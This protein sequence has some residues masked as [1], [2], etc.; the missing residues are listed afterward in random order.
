MKRLYYALRLGD[1]PL[2][3]CR[4]YLTVSEALLT[5]K[6]APKKALDKG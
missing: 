1:K 4:D 3:S 5:A 2:C 6:K